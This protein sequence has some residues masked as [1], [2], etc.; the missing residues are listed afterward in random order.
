MAVSRFGMLLD[1]LLS[2]G[3]EGDGIYSAPDL[4]SAFLGGI[5]ELQSAGTPFPQAV[6]NAAE[7]YVFEGGPGDRTGPV[8]PHNA[9]PSADPESI[10]GELGLHAEMS[11][12]DLARLRRS[13]A[14]HNHP[15]RVPAQLRTLAT[16]RM[17]V[18]N[19]LIDQAKTDRIRRSART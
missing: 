1:S 2:K 14:M 10:A 11:L 6:G 19:R 18:A 3:G 4:S 9:L 5:I 17:M 16:T 15:D 7:A 8:E 12:A 13:F